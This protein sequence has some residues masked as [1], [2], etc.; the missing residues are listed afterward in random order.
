M[1]S[2]LAAEP[3]EQGEEQD[4]YRSGYYRI[5]QQARGEEAGG[6]VEQGALGDG[7]DCVM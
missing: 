7:K 5:E 2:G 3:V 1:G 6:L 4:A